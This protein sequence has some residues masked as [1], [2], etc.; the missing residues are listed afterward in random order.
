MVLVLD[1]KKRH[2]TRILLVI[3]EGR[4]LHGWS[5]FGSLRGQS[6]CVLEML[7]SQLQER[8]KRNDENKKKHKLTAQILHQPC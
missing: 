8:V 3:V 4:C 6:G 7:Y 1:H 2:R 5:S